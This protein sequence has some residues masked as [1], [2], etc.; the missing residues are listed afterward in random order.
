MDRAGETRAWLKTRAFFAAKTGPHLPTFN[1]IV[2]PR[3]IIIHSMRGMCVLLAS[4]QLNR[5]ER[6]GRGSILGGRYCTNS[7]HKSKQGNGYCAQ[8]E[9]TQLIQ[10][11]HTFHMF[12]LA[13]KDCWNLPQGRA[14]SPLPKT[15]QIRVQF[16]SLLG[17]INSFVNQIFNNSFK[18]SRRVKCHLD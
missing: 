13:C 3:I 18:I 10:S 9:S 16:H 15:L 8:F 12:K 17:L 7:Q 11:V 1:I 14:R 5:L 4:I 6:Q 2:T